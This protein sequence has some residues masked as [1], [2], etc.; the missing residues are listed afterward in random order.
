[1]LRPSATATL[2][3]STIIYIHESVTSATTDTIPP[4]P[5]PQALNS[6]LFET[7]TYKRFSQLVLISLKVC[8]N[9]RQIIISKRPL[10]RC[11]ASKV[12]CRFSL[13]QC[14]RTQDIH[15]CGC[16]IRNYS[17]NSQSYISRCR[18]DLENAIS[19]SERRSNLLKERDE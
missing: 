10:C 3:D 4:D 6:C 8:P 15:G 2:E 13:P 18:S 11:Q 1:M 17:L 16:R 7:T 14:Q 19:D 9:S 12:L 5:E